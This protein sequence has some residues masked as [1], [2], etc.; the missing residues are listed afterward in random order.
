MK[1]QVI[2]IVAGL[3]M[4]VGLI[5]AVRQIRIEHYPLPV[6]PSPEWQPFIRSLDA[7]RESYF[8][9]SDG[10]LLEADL[11]VPNGGSDNKPA[12]VFSSGSG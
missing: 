7:Q 10:T 9:N 12:V 4:V 3:L 2:R 6:E 1:K 8:V 5:F 11:F